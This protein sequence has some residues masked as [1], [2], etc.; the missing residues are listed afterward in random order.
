MLMKITNE[1]SKEKEKIIFLFQ[2]YLIRT[3]AEG[4]YYQG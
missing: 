4:E 3:A 1:L 2:M